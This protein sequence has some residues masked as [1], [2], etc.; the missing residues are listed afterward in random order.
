MNDTDDDP[1]EDFLLLKIIRSKFL[2]AKKMIKM[3]NINI[4]M[5]K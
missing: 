5:S 3:V 4:N 1:E 2:S